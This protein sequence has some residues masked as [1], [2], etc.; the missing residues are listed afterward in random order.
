MTKINMDELRADREAGTDG[1]WW[2]D[3]RYS[4]Q[5]AGCSIIAARTD[6]G[7]LPGNP[8]R[9]AVAFATALLN[10]ESRRCEANARRIA[11]LPDLEAAFLEAVE[12]LK[13]A[14]GIIENCS[15]E[16]GY[17]CCG[18]KMDD[19][20]IHSGHSPVDQGAYSADQF[21]RAAKDYLG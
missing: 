4:G 17:C 13:N 12:L 19:H 10:T 3:A 16:C 1:P 8:T 6:A 7:P 9:G 20:S 14:M 21:Y 11:R 15:V 5:D 18:C 2:T